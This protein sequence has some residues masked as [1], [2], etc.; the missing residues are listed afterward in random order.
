MSEVEVFLDELRAKSDKNEDI[1]KQAEKLWRLVVIEKDYKVPKSESDNLL[2][3]NRIGSKN[4]NLS[5]RD[6]FNESSLDRF[7]EWLKSWQYG[8]NDLK[9]R[10]LFARLFQLQLD[11]SALKHASFRV[12]PKNK[13]IR[14]LHLDHMEPSITGGLT[15]SILY[16]DSDERGIHVNGL[17]NMFPLPGDLNISKSNKPLNDCWEYL[18]NSGLDNHWLVRESK[19]IFKENENKNIPTENFFKKRKLFLI[20]K[21]LDAIKLGGL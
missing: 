17:G 2:V 5:L 18:T 6:S 14:D 21:F 8:N 20:D 11:D 4:L 7:S 12:L 9:I 3:N 15:S 16:F 13:D 1:H 19:T 10:I